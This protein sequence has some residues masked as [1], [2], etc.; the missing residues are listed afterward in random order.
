MTSATDLARELSAVLENRASALGKVISAQTDEVRAYTA[1]RMTHLA[2][3]LGQPGYQLTLIAERD[4]VALKSGL[5]AVSAA[6]AADGE[7]IGLV[8]GFLGAAARAVAP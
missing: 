8:A 3:L 7:L 2:G 1:E 6:D 5:S 4:N